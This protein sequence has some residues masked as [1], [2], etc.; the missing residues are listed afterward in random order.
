MPCIRTPRGIS[1]LERIKEA[2]RSKI[3]KH[4]PLQISNFFQFD[5]YIICI[6]T[7]DSIQSRAT[8][9]K[10]IFCYKNYKI[11]QEQR[12]QNLMLMTNFCL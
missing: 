6:I 9:Y 2:R 3:T 8:T 5:I 4:K 12:N 10:I 11:R 7:V 1:F